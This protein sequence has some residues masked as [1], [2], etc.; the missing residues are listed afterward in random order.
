[1]Q[2]IRIKNAIMAKLITKS[3]SKEK[4]WL[5]KLKAKYKLV[6]LDDETLQEAVSFRLSRLNVFIALG[7]LSILLIFLTTYIIAFTPLREY[8]PG[9]MDVSLQ[10]KV[11]YLQLQ[12]DSLELEFKRRELVLQNIRNII[13]GKVSYEKKET[14]PEGSIVKNYDSIVMKS[15]RAD[16]LFRA[17]YEAKNQ[18]AIYNMPNASEKLSAPVKLINFFTPLKGVIVNKFNSAQN[19]YG[20]DVVAN[21]NEAI[22]AA[23]DGVIMMSS[24]TLETGY[25]IGIQHQNN[26][27][28]MYKH[29]SALLKKMGEHVR[30]GDPIAIVGNSGEYSTGPHLH[31]E[32]WSNGNPVDPLN[33]IKF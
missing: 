26:Y 7:S 1:M 6:I 5:K 17:E 21:K 8:I 19:H 29:C 13:E 15:S 23:Y 28:T 9:Y 10:K 33:Y 2:K 18:F 30:S 11:Y 20:I 12:A 4:I 22:K 31:F 3:Q 14:R 27:I 25:V 24:W 32:L 16:S